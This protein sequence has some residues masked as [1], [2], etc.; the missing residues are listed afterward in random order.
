M[1]RARNT[2][3]LAGIAVTLAWMIAIPLG[4]WVG[5]AL[6]AGWIDW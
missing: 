4:I 5:I 3:L 1:L 6:A 2:L